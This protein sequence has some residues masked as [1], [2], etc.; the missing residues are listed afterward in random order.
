VQLN[1]CYTGLA[2]WRGAGALAI[3]LLAAASAVCAEERYS[4]ANSA[5][6]V[7]T[8]KM[9]SLHVMPWFDGW[10]VWGTLEIEEVLAGNPHG[11]SLEYRFRACPIFSRIPDFSVLRGEGLWYL[12]P[13][14]PGVLV[15]YTGA[16]GDPGFSSMTDHPDVIQFLRMGGRSRQLTRVEWDYLD[17]L[18]EEVR[19]RYVRGAG[20]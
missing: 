9:K 1:N 13:G 8:G 5:E 10:H 11:K 15:P 14:G 17:R 12:K 2:R 20:R 18:Q 7:V 3:I 19:L 4:S 6:I 16:C